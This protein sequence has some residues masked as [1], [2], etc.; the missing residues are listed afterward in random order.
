MKKIILLIAF[1]VFFLNSQAQITYFHYLDYQTEWRN[2]YGGWS[3]FYSFTNF[4]THYFDG[5]TLLSNGKR[6]YKSYYVEVDSNYTT[7]ITVNVSGPKGPLL[8]REDSTKKLWDFNFNLGVE[9]VY[10]DYGKYRN[11]LVGDTVPDESCI[12]TSVDSIHF[13]SKYLRRFTSASIGRFGIEGMGKTMLLCATGVEG[14]YVLICFKNG[15]DS[16]AFD[17]TFS[18]YNSFPKPQRHSVS[19][20]ILKIIEHPILNI[21]PNPTSNIVTVESSSNQI[22]KHALVLDLLGRKVIDVEENSS[23]IFLDLS[24]LNSSTYILKTQVGND[25][26]IRKIVKN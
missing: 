17:N 19:S 21:F 13:D 5:D 12:I 11:V 16:I 26:L 8:L 2:I 20:G 1:T 25:W 3:G 18:C 24:S 4:Y 14:N 10:A 22:I 9:E 6:Y 7:P 23:K 15:R